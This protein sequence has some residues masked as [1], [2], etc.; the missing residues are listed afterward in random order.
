MPFYESVHVGI[1]RIS[2]NEQY[3]WKWLTQNNKSKN[4][5]VT[6]LSLMIEDELHL[7]DFTKPLILNNLIF[8]VYDN[9]VSEQ[10][11]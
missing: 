11:K 3:I 1:F 4:I 9:Y 10:T 5:N 8:S 6:Q 7:F 2:I